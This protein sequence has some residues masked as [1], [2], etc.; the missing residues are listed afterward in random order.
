MNM[1]AIFASKKVLLLLCVTV[2][3]TRYANGIIV[4]YI[5]GPVRCIVIDTFEDVD[6]DNVEIM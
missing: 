1:L 2:E 4:V 5:Q 6:I 3:C